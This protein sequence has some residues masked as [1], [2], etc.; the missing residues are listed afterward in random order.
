MNR[1]PVIEMERIQV[2]QDT[3]GVELPGLLVDI[4]RRKPS[5]K[6]LKK[7]PNT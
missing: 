3:F 1:W 6:E 5:K 7:I 2:C 4:W